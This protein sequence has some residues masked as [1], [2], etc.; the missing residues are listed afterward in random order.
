M[1][2]HNQLSTFSPTV[3]S[4]LSTGGFIPSTYSS[5]E[6]STIKSGNYYMYGV[7]AVAVLALDVCVFS[8]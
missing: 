7:G 5:T 2:K 3:N 4:T 6:N 1:L 8:I